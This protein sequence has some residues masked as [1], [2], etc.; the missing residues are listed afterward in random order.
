[1]FE[2]AF[3]FCSKIVLFIHFL[4]KIEL[5]NLFFETYFSFETFET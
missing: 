5:E 4:E 3:K 2:G 1:M